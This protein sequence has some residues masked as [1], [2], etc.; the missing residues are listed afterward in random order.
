M[1]ALGKLL[2][3]INSIKTFIKVKLPFDEAL[4]LRIDKCLNRG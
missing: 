3:N 4:P 2:L 1:R